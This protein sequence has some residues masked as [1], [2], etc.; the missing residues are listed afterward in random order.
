MDILDKK[1]EAMGGIAPGMQMSDHVQVKNGTILKQK[2]K[3]FLSSQS[4]KYN[5]KKYFLPMT[6]LLVYI[7]FIFLLDS[8]IFK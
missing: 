7:L 5:Y 2:K 6:R 4:V 1:A 3:F 8:N